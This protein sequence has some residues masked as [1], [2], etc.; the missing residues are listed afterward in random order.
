[1]NGPGPEVGRSYG[2]SVGRSVVPWVVNIY[3]LH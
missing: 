1:V 2:R 3:F